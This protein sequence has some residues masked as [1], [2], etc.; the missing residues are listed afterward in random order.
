MPVKTLDAHFT[1]NRQV[2]N[3]ARYFIKLQTTLTRGE[4]SLSDLYPFSSK[5]LQAFLKATGAHRAL[6]LLYHWHNM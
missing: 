3:G 6:L 1:V 2:L 5:F 4:N